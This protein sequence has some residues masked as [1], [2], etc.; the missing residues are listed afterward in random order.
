[1]RIRLAAAPQTVP[2]FVFLYGNQ[3]NKIISSVL[4]VKYTNQIDH[5]LCH[6]L[7]DRD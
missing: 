4:A 2:V 1:M 7:N 3:H 5:A 6:H